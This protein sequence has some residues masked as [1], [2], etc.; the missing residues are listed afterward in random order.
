VYRCD[1]PDIHV[2][3]LL[4]ETPTRLLRWP[5]LVIGFCFG[6]FLA[7]LLGHHLADLLATDRLCRDGI[8]ASPHQSLRS[9]Q[10]DARAMARRSREA[11]ITGQQRRVERF[12][13]GD[14]H[15]VMGREI[16]PQIPDALQQ[17]VVWISMQGKIGEVGQ[18]HAAALG[19]DFTVSR[20]PAN[21]LRNFDVEQVG[22][23]QRL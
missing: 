22:R 4:T 5:A 13:K 20:I 6:I 10:V 12:G 14:V 1:N 16:V 11:F 8:A 3:A 18:S 2:D 9:D 21:H 15:G 23:V 19:I 7:I 17:E